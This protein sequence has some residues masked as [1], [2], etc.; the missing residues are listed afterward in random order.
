[1]VVQLS[2]L[3]GNVADLLSLGY[4]SIEVHQSK[5]DSNSFQEVTAPAISPAVLDSLPANTT[6]RMGGKLLKLKI[7]G[8]AEVAV[9]FSTVVEFWTTAQVVNR[10]NEVIPALASIGPDAVVRL[11]SATVGRVS[12]IEIVYNDATDLGWIAGVVYGKSARILLVAGTFSYLFPDVAGIASDRYKWRYSANGSNPISPFSETV[13]DQSAPSI[14]VGNLS[15]GTAKFYGADGKPKKTRIL[16]ATD[17]VPQGLVGVFVVRDQPIIV[18]SD[19]DGFLQLTVIR[20]ATIRVAIEG[21]SY[22]REFVVPDAT[23]FDLLT[24]MATATDPFTIQTTP[25]LLSRRSI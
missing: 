14:S 20:G 19:D 11:T 5:D 8:G 16:V 21:T 24:V 6:F 2:I 25:P 9:S 17:S 10:I 18:D 3:V 4:T 13:S 1:M 15:V 12:S 7:D 23:A 22:I